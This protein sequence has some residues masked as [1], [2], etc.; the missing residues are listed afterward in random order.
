MTERDALYSGYVREI[1]AYKHEIEQWRLYAGC[2]TPI[3]LHEKLEL[4]RKG[5]EV[6]KVK[7]V[8]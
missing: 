1:E 2:R 5:L 7:V 4:V 6:L 8:D 3:E